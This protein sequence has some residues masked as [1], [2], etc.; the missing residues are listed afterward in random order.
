MDEVITCFCGSR[1]W[2]I[3]TSG[4]RCSKCDTFLKEK[5]NIDIPTINKR[6][7]SERI[8]ETPDV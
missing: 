4:I 2:I 6:I 3:G 5:I 1:N 7:D 8:K